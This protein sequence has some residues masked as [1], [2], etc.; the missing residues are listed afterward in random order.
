[1]NLEKCQF[2]CDGLQ[3]LPITILLNLEDKRLLQLFPCGRLKIAL[4]LKFLV[5]NFFKNFIFTIYFAPIG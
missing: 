5:K 4:Y 2:D 1:M 3:A